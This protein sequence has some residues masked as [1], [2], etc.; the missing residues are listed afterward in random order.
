MDVMWAPWRMEYILGEK[1]PGCI[2]CEK[3][4]E[5]LEEDRKN[6]ILYRGKE[7]F[8]ILNKYPY[9]NGHLLITP[10]R[11]VPD[12]SFLNEDELL[13]LMLLSQKLLKTMK[14]A[15]K[16][17]GFNMGINQGKVA[18]AGIEAHVHLH[19][20]PRWDGDTN[21]MPVVNSAR[22][23]PQHLTDTYDILKEIIDKI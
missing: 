11:H 13:E 15:M 16:P 21:F 3:P 1:D 12:I 14:K 17:D 4:G 19:I 20:V 6:L 9:N 10:Y 7:C 18:G 5:G 23:I 8:V 22:V 2:F